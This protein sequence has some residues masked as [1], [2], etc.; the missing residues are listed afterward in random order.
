M[1]NNIHHHRAQI[2]NSTNLVFKSQLIV[3]Q[4]E[5]ITGLRLNKEKSTFYSSLPT[6]CSN[7]QNKLTIDRLIFGML[8]TRTHS[9]PRLALPLEC[10]SHLDWVKVGDEQTSPVGFI[11]QCAGNDISD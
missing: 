10:H 6:T 9:H 8:I 4:M 3:F 5:T 2:L 11:S 1:Y 7:T